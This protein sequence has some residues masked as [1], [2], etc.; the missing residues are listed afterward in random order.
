MK[1]IDAAPREITTTWPNYT[2]EAAL[3]ASEQVNW[4]VE[5]LIGGDKRLDFSQREDF[6]CARQFDADESSGCRRSGPVAVFD[7][8]AEPRK[9]EIA[10]VGAARA[11]V[12]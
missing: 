7:R 3:A 5:D 6:V 1:A 12:R 2:F 8:H 9:H 10:V 4:R 11:P